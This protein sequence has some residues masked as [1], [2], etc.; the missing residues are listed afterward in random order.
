MSFYSTQY[1]ALSI[2]KFFLF[3]LIFVPQD[4]EKASNSKSEQNVKLE[5]EMAEKQKSIASFKAQYV[6]IFF[7]SSQSVSEKF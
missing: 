6:S 4:H 2:Y 7:I 5:K 3:Y 1:T